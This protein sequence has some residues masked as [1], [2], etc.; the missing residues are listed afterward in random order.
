M[1]LSH[2]LPKHSGWRAVARLSLLFAALAATPARADNLQIRYNVKLIGL[3]LGTA[4]LTGSI[5][6]GTYRVDATA[7]LAGVATIVSNAKGAATSSGVFVQGRVAPNGFATTSANSQMTR[8]IRIAMQAGTVK[9]SE[10]TPPFDSPPDRI[11]V[12]E[13]HKRNVIDPLSAMIM[14]VSTRDSAA[15]PA[16]CNRVI[17]I[18][19]GWT[20]FDIALTYAGKR[21]VE[22]KGYS[23]P[24]SVCAARYTP[25][26]G[27]RDRP[28]VRYMTDN[29]Q[30]EVWLA[31]IGETHAAVPVYIGVETQ[32]GKLVIEA[33]DFVVAPSGKA[34]QR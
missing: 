27:H 26:S 15:G 17:P 29:K 18:F 11:P 14:P 10:I 4:G 20:R 34:A 7:K 28:V 3:S 22:L 1:I 21:D 13:A 25:I 9:A 31:P 30:M 32:I 2:V 23:G 16:A 33:T 12:L 24:V 6:S 8:T 5:D 19:D